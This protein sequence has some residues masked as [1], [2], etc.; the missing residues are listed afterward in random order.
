MIIAHTA[1]HCGKETRKLVKPEEVHLL[2]SFPNAFPST[3][4]N[5]F[6]TEL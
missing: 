5:I 3:Y 4:K 6:G 1:G 2:I